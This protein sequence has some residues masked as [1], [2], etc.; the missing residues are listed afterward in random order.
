MN[1]IF[2]V[3]ERQKSK[4]IKFTKDLINIP[5]INPPGLNYKRFIDLLERRCKDAGLATTRYTVPAS[6]LKEFKI[7]GGS[8]RINLVARWDTGKRKTLHINSHY[9]VVPATGQWS[10]DPFRATVKN[11]RLFGRGSEDMKANI[12]CII[13]A[14]A[15][16]KKLK[17]TPQVNIELSFT[18]DEETGGQAG[19]AY[20]LKKKLVKADYAIGEGYEDDYVSIGNKGMLWLAVEVLGKSAHSS[21]PYKGENSFENMLVVANRLTNFKK[22]LKRRKTK[23]GTRYKVEAY[24]TMVVG[25]LIYGG[26]KINIVPDNSAF[27]IDRRLIPE[28]KV[29]QATKEI[30]QII[31]DTKIKNK[32][33]KVKIKTLTAEDAVVAKQDKRLIRAFSEAVKLVL[34]K[35][36]KTAIMPGGTDLRFF[37][38]RGIPAI[39]Y[40]VQGGNRAHADN[41]FVYVKSIINTAKIFALLMSNLN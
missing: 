15:V 3:L 6:K 9:D 40:S 17:I 11:G 30:R 39:G 31:K 27:T 41:E 32:K 12:A 34:K 36:L 25:G 26:K 7:K 33:L 5:T 20:L 4:I 38:R 16:L 37:M 10:G 23:Y 28:E 35:K 24:S 13:F 2:D 22:R 19:L 21:V 29:I 18:P 8:P 14:V 1:E